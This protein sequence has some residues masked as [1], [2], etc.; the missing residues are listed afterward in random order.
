[1]SRA[2]R[3][4]AGML[5]PQ[6]IVFGL[7]S[8]W[9]AILPVV[10]SDLWAHLRGFDTLAGTYLRPSVFRLNSSW[11]MILP[12]QTRS[13]GLRAQDGER[14]IRAKAVSQNLMHENLSI[15]DGIYAVLSDIEVRARITTL[16]S[17]AALM[18]ETMGANDR[19][20]I[21]GLVARLVA[22]FREESMAAAKKG[23]GPQR[24]SLQ[25]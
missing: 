23:R 6:P 12:L 15:T 22:L 3:Q 21:E 20:E 17:S 5:R 1:M 8:S 16:G 18:P 7:N 11:D 2:K 4:W 24:S 14:R 9:A 25:E 13:R 19:R 10:A